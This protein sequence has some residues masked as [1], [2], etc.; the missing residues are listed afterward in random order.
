MQQTDNVEYLQ[1]RS[2][3]LHPE[4]AL[5]LGHFSEHG[6]IGR[7]HRVK[8]P[9]ARFIAAGRIA[10]ISADI[11]EKL[12]PKPYVKLT[13]T[14]LDMPVS[15]FANMTFEARWQDAQER[16]LSAARK[17]QGK[18]LTTLLLFTG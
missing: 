8:L 7:E 10:A 13:A 9:A 4:R 16:Y 15:G 2:P 17:K 1:H 11:V 12:L 5:I 3:I 14:S 6:A 18:F